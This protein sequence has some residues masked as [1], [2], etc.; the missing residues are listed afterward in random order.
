M[1]LLCH[2]Y[3]CYR[4]SYA[5]AKFISAKLRRKTLRA[6]TW[7][8]FPSVTSAISQHSRNTEEWTRIC[9]YCVSA[10]GKVVEK[11]SDSSTKPSAAKVYR[12]QNCSRMHIFLSFQAT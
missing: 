11:L 12:D 8:Q 1:S 7:L 10:N 5:S 3:W 9:H 6:V 2:K 4:W